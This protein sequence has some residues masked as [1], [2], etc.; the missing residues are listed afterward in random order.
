MPALGNGLVNGF[1]N[2]LG[3]GL[4]NGLGNACLGEW[5]GELLGKWLRDRSTRPRPDSF[6]TNF[7]IFDAYKGTKMVKNANV[8]NSLACFWSFLSS[9]WAPKH[10]ETI[11]I[12]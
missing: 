7:H 10:Y 4:G 2:D 11:L 12:L 1:G 5:F 8:S 9:L 3:N 6:L